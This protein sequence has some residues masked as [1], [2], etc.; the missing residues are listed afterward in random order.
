MPTYE[1]ACGNCNKEFEDIYGM[2]APVP[3]LC[4]LCGHDGKVVRLVSGGS[5]KGI[6]TLSG[7]EFKAKLKEDGRKLKQ[8]ALK[9]EKVLSNLIGETKYQDNTVK[10][11]K[12]IA[13]LDRPKIKR[14]KSD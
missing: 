11:E 3:T 6:V 14:K 7:N 13:N 2:M 10:L 12:Q 4:P 1:H 9:D 5:G 8:A